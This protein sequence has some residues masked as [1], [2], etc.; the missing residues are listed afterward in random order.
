MRVL[1]S[2]ALAGLLLSAGIAAAATT[3][4]GDLRRGTMVTIEGTVD[5]ILDTDEFRLRD[6][7][8]A[9]R[10]YLGPNW[11]P[12]DVGQQVTVRGFVDDGW[13]VE[14]YAREI[15]LPDGRTLQFSH[16]YD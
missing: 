7:S 4:I 5:R 9:V 11:V 16:R 12:V 10:I 2:L 15:I 1:S 6:R 3:P 8:G 13:P 14:V